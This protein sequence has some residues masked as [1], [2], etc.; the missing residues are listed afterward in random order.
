[1]MKMMTRRKLKVKIIDQSVEILYPRSLADGVEELKRVEKAGRN[2]W[3]SEGKITEDSYR[4]F[5]DN[6]RKRGHESPLEFGHIMV[7]FVTSRDVLAELTRHRIGVAFAVESQRY[8]NEAREDGGIRFI[9]PLFY[10]EPD[11]ALPTV[12]DQASFAW[13]AAMDYAEKVYNNLIAIGLRNE[14]A[15][16]VLPNSTATTIIM[17]TNLRELLHIYGLRSSQ[18]AYPEMRALMQL[19]KTETDKVLPGFLPEEET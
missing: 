18:A 10:K 4:R 6:L 5:V 7:K 15:R 2:C 14:D 8:V 16:K 3:R 11:L 9:R 17:D 19:L 1:M 13:E 12:L